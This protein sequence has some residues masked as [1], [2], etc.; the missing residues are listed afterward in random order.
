[1]P[2]SFAARLQVSESG[3]VFDPQTGS[4]FSLNHTGVRLVQMIKE[5]RS[6]DQ[7][8]DALVKEY[9]IEPADARRDIE[10]FTI[11]LKEFSKF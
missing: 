9:A 1:M 7:L 3:F 6:Q 8:I 2:Q 11:A 10:D 5:G 4:T